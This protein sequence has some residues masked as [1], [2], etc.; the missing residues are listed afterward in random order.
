MF[1]AA[2][3]ETQIS[4]LGNISKLSTH[5]IK[6]FHKNVLPK[7]PPKTIFNPP[8]ILFLT[9]LS[10][11][12]TPWNLFS[13][14]L[15]HFQHNIFCQK[16]N[17]AKILCPCRRNFFRWQ[18]IIYPPPFPSLFQ[19][20]KEKKWKNIN[21]QHPVSLSLKICVIRK[22]ENQKGKGGGSF[23]WCDIALP[24]RVPLP[25]HLSSNPSPS[26]KAPPKPPVFMH[27]EGL[28]RYMGKE[29]ACF[30]GLFIDDFL[31]ET[32]FLFN[33]GNKYDD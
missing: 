17:L 20:E 24:F 30:Y 21:S 27:W 14:Y 1:W 33:K 5:N 16:H 18:I 22:R 11:F 9:F 25:F 3:I 12:L 8:K 10:L 28:E 29:E 31:L 26:P 13:A 6:L 32:Y 19:K 4:K 23:Y 7:I 15:R 2:V